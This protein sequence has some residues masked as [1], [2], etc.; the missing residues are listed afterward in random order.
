MPQLM[1]VRLVV[2]AKLEYTPNF[3]DVVTTPLD[4]ML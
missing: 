3:A 2:Q 1:D 4:E